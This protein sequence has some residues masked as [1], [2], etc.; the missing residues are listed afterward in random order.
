MVNQVN[1]ANE[2]TP[3]GSLKD[4]PKLIPTDL[5]VPRQ[6]DV[7]DFGQGRPLNQAQIQDIVVDRALEKLRDIVNDARAQLGLPEGAVVDTSPEATANRIADFALGFFGQ[8]AE[9]NGLEDNEE[10]R[11]QY[12]E[13]IGGAVS[14]GIEEARGILEALNALN[15]E[16]SGN[17]DQTAS[18][19]QDRFDSFV[20]NGLN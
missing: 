6:K 2:G 15:P 13:F 7:V 8:Y 3:L 4:R 12:A 10:G 17:I 1:P 18:L 11:R 20:L 9:N 14:Q 19:V 5:R 16:V